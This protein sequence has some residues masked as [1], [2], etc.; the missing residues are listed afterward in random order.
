MTF[1]PDRLKGTAMQ[2]RDFLKSALVTAGAI[3]AGSV[4]RTVAADET[5]SQD[6][7]KAV[8][9]LSSQEWIV[10]GK[11]LKEKVA[12]IVAYGGQGI[13]LGSH[14]LEKRHKEVEEA[15]AGTD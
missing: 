4:A 12:N 9:K 15:L 14:D 5:S 6:K 2:R 13:E 3:G 10:P 11:S 1:S 7:P 8:L